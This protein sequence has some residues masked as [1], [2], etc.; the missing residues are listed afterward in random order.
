MSSIVQKN[1][2]I[3]MAGYCILNCYSESKELLNPEES[4]YFEEI[5]CCLL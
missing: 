5:F 3:E 2:T 1:C 4:S